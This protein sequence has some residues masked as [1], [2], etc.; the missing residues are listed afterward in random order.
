MHMVYHE[1]MNFVALLIQELHVLVQ[2]T[3]VAADTHGHKP[4]ADSTCPNGMLFVCFLPQ[5]F[6]ELEQLYLLA[7]ILCHT[8]AS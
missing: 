8:T 4:V 3:P 2:G 1:L 6:P 7:I 5:Q